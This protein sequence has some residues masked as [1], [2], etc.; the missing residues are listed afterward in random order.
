MN[1]DYLGNPLQS[2]IDAVG[3]AQALPYTFGGAPATSNSISNYPAMATGQ[4][5]GLTAD[6]MWRINAMRNADYLNNGTAN[7][8]LPNN[9]SHLMNVHELEQGTATPWSTQPLSLGGNSNMQGLLPSSQ[10]LAENLNKAYDYNPS[11]FQRPEGITPVADLASSYGG[12]PQ[13]QPASAQAP[14]SVNDQLIQRYMQRED[15]AQQ[16]LLRTQYN[17]ALQQGDYPTANAIAAQA[18]GI[19]NAAQGSAQYLDPNQQSSTFGQIMHMLSGTPDKSLG[20]EHGGW[21][22]AGQAAF[23]LLMSAYKLYRQQQFLNNAGQMV[24]SAS[25]VAHQQAQQNAMNQLGY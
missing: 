14:M 9:P 24:N 15:A 18:N 13:L 6:N 3:G 5:A 22:Q 16:A 4:Q 8:V 19:S 21:M 1:T 17:A 12:S 10:Q 25:N 23:P 2:T 20:T 11:T 7:S